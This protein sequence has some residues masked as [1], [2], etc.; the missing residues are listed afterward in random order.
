MAKHILGLWALLL[1]A[2]RP[3]QALR[4]SPAGVPLADVEKYVGASLEYVKNLI[5]T[6]ELAAEELST[7]PN[8][9]RIPGI[10]WV[11]KKTGHTRLESFL[12]EMKTP[13]Y[14][15]T[16]SDLV[17][18][19]CV[20]SDF[21]NMST[22]KGAGW[23]MLCFH[24]GMG[25][26]SSDPARQAENRFDIDTFV[27]CG[28]AKI[29][30]KEDCFGCMGQLLS[31]N[32]A[33]ACTSCFYDACANECKTCT[34]AGVTAFQTC[35]GGSWVK[36]GQNQVCLPRKTTTTAPGDTTAPLP[37]FADLPAPQSWEKDWIARNWK[38]SDADIDQDFIT[39]ST[40][41]PVAEPL[42]NI[43]LPFKK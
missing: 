6:A 34:Q 3:A 18:A 38:D 42:P 9:M 5:K 7:N 25:W 13:G 35:V 32:V 23:M 1:V 37:G 41:A 11:N 15:P 29:G 36:F 31:T 17:G 28:A 24:M 26:W 10:P 33:N 4:A 20:P 40:E 12:R 43:T 39:R 8:M 27:Q 14:Q 16:A 19:S 21:T 22:A 30:M 2:V